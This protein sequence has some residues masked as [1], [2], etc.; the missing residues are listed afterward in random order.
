MAILGNRGKEP[1][2]AKG[3]PNDPLKV[4]KALA[5]YQEKGTIQ[6]AADTKCP[7]R[8]VAWDT[9]YTGR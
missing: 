2:T 5:P 4:V 1:V 8:R 9:P 7:M 3:L 6:V